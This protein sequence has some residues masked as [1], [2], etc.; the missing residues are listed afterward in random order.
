MN[1]SNYLPK[2]EENVVSWKNSRGEKRYIRID[3]G[4][5]YDVLLRSIDR[6]RAE[7]DMY[8]ELV[9]EQEKLT[10]ADH[11]QSLFSM[12]VDEPQDDTP[13]YDD[14]AL[15]MNEVPNLSRERH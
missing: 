14:D 9:E 6:M 4:I 15:E 13:K 8:L 7:E 10:E 11:R 3:T 2:R 12:I 1:I 5:S